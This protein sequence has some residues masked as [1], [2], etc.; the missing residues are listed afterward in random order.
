MFNTDPCGKP[1]SIQVSLTPDAQCRAGF[2]PCDERRLA[3]Q[4]S[5]ILTAQ[6]TQLAKKKKLVSWRAMALLS[7]MDPYPTPRSTPCCDSTVGASKHSDPE[8]KG[9]EERREIKDRTR[10][11]GFRVNNQ[12]L[13]RIQ[14]GK[15]LPKKLL[16]HPLLSA[17]PDLNPATNR[18]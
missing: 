13:T 16:L 5:P 12:Y 14:A 7:D 17:E 10:R 18:E 4:K 11:L 6:T 15:Q 3:E 1:I 2:E 8:K 9:K